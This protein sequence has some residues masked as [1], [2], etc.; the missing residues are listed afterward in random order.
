MQLNLPEC[1]LS[2]RETL[3]G[4]E[5]FDPFR[6]K[7]VTL[8]P[9]EWVRQNFLSFM[10]T[11]LGFPKGLVAVE[12]Q[13]KVNGLVRRCDILAFSRT[14]KPILLVECK[15]SSVQLSN[16]VFAQAARY[17][18]TLQ[19]PFMIITNGLTHYAAQLFLGEKRFSMLNTFPSF[20]MIAGV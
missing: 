1:N 6:N 18:L 16:E 14:A 12:Q 8:T 3:V 20:E 2:I 9:E 5:V 10:V 19:V 7:F 17:N 11:Q 4:K 15:A 13:L